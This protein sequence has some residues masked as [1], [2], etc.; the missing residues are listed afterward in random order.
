MVTSTPGYSV[1]TLTT[2]DALEAVRPL[3][4][5][6]QRHPLADYD[7]YALI[8]RIRAPRTQPCVLALLDNGTPL[9]LLVGRID[10]EDKAIRVGYATLGT[11]PTQQLRFIAGGLLGDPAAHHLAHFTR[12][13]DQLM[14]TEGISSAVFESIQPT[15]A[16][17]TGLRAVYGWWRCAAV[18]G[19]SRHWRLTL[20]D[21]WDAFLK[22]RST[23]HRYWINR[24]PRVLDREFPGRWRIETC[25][26]LVQAS[27]FIHAADAVTAKTYHRA[28]GVGFRGTAEYI[29]R[30]RLEA[31]HGRLK[32]YVLF[33]DESP[34]A[35]WYC[36]AYHDTLH[37][38]ATAYDPAFKTYEVGT[39]LLM[40]VLKEQCGTALRHIDFGLGDADYKQR[41]GS[42]SFMEG[43]MYVFS[44]SLKGY[45]MRCFYEG[46][47]IINQVARTV[48]DR[49]G[50]TQGLKTRWKNKLSARATGIAQT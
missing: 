36:V 32:G 37:L 50:A 11:L 28:L 39:V 48:F 10:T 6:H 4:E 35:F 12:A 22:G 25:T 16:T 13:I 44:P 40:Q 38:I 15:T 47:R 34:K 29:E 49:L 7:F 2:L 30:V 45:A 41:F 19:T 24:L 21:T 1:A 14:R 9:A 26:T 8:C 3:W 46:M 43:P 5:A 33:I 18:E 23:K 17:D 42:E 20:P 31:Q 27:T